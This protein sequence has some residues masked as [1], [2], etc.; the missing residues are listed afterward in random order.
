VPPAP[1]AGLALHAACN[2]TPADLVLPSKFVEI[3]I[4]LFP[5]RPE[6]DRNEHPYQKAVGI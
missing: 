4:K 3:R 5:I 6:I 1:S 2:F